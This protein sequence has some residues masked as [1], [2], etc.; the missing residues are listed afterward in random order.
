[1]TLISG[2]VGVFSSNYPFGKGPMKMIRSSLLS[3]LVG[4]FALSCISFPNLGALKFEA[5]PLYIAPIIRRNLY[6][7]GDGWQLSILWLEGQLQRSVSWSNQKGACATSIEVPLIPRSKPWSREIEGVSC[8]SFGPYQPAYTCQ[9]NNKRW[10]VTFLHE[11]VEYDTTDDL[12]RFL[13]WDYYNTPSR[14]ALS[15]EGILVVF[16]KNE[17]VNHATLNIEVRYL[18]VDGGSPPLGVL[19]QFLKGKVR[20]TS[21]VIHR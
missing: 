16:S 6:A 19:D 4:F 21:V 8:T 2:A 15:S 12:T 20:E 14:V 18:T 17:A 10:N 9:T 13:A 11:R 5:A 3:I 7:E 1:M